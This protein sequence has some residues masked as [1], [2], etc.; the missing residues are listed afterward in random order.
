[1]NIG[2]FGGA[3]NPVHNG[4]I[5]LADNYFS[6]LHLDRIIFIPT[7]VPPHKTAQ[8]FAP[9]QDRINMLELALR[10]RENY[11]VSTIEFER[12]GKSYTY[13]TLQALKQ[14][15]PDSKFFLI[16]GAD[17]FMTFHCWYKY[18]EILEMVTI[19]TSARE[20]EAEKKKMLD[21]AKTLDELDGKYYISNQ[22]VLKLSSSD[23]R[24]KVKDGEDISSLVPVK[25]CDYISEKRLYCV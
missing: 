16:I 15:Y 9:A 7:S 23:V 25:V 1:M 10:D 11:E 18:K 13:D 4:H 14:I 2:I 5:N 6:A 20:D 24:Q 21:Y 3:F 22:P 17:Q 19:C 8:D 12:A